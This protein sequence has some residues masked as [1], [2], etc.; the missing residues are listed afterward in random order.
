MALVKRK[1]RNADL[2]IVC[3]VDQYPVGR[4]IRDKAEHVFEEQRIIKIAS[5]EV[6]TAF[7]LSAVRFCLVLVY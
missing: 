1:R 3:A 6:E 5:A 4:R 7:A 2:L